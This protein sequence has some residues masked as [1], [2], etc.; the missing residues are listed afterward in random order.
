MTIGLLEGDV[1]QIAVLNHWWILSNIFRLFH[2][3]TQI[4]KILLKIYNR[5]FF[6]EGNMH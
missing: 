6:Q 1:F 4:H 3:S 5:I 2:L